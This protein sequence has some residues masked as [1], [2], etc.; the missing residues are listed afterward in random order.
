MTPIAWLTCFL[1]SVLLSP[2][3]SDIEV[4]LI[5]IVRT[6]DET[7]SEDCRQ[8]F[9]LSMTCIYVRKNEKAILT[10]QRSV[11]YCTKFMLV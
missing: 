2:D 11:L 10:K 8:H 9:V 5:G 4:E 1:R 6:F 3:E 7:V